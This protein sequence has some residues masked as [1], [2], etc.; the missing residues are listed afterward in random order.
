MDFV[1]CSTGE[2]AY[3][4]KDYLST[5]HWRSFSRN[6]RIAVGKCSECGDTKKSTTH[7]LNYDNIGNEKEGDVQVLCWS[8]H[9]SKHNCPNQPD[10]PIRA[11]DESRTPKDSRNKMFQFSLK[12]VSNMSGKSEKD[13]LLLIRKGEV[14]TSEPRSVARLFLESIVNMMK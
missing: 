6:M 10:N 3:T 5:H 13:I 1:L 11:T 7:H 9:R 14:N 4:Y 12:D 8:C 2:I